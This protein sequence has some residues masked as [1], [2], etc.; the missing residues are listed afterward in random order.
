MATKNCK[1]KSIKK[2]K[3]SKTSSRKPKTQKGGNT[4]LNNPLI[5][6]RKGN[7]SAKALT[8]TNCNSTM[9]VAKT[10]TLGTKLKA[11]IKAEF[12]DNRYQ[13]F[14]CR[15]CGFVQMYSNEITCDDKQCDSGFNRHGL[16][17]PT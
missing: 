15:S 11:L 6:Y 3:K 9:F 14:T 7:A 10:M 12:F 17:V 16:I 8:C 1:N 13:V 5:K 4:K 2:S